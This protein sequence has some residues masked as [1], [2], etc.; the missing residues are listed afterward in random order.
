MHRSGRSTW[1][2]LFFIRKLIGP[3]LSL[4]MSGLFSKPLIINL[5]S[6]GVSY[7]SEATVFYFY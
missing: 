1:G 7:V 3:V 6:G 2:G 4:S 5:L